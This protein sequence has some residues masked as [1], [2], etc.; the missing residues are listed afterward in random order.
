MSKSSLSFY[1]VCVPFGASWWCFCQSNF[2]KIFVG[3]CVCVCICACVCVCCMCVCVFTTT[4][5]L[6]KVYGL[7]MSPSPSWWVCC[8]AIPWTCSGAFSLCAL[9]LFKVF[10]KH[11]TVTPLASGLDHF[12]LQRITTFYPGSLGCHMLILESFVI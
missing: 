1:K 5:S 10:R 2:L 6:E 11:F 4:H 8:E 7:E 3:F 12:F 9:E